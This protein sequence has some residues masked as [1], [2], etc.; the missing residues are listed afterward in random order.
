MAYVVLSVGHSGN[1]GSGRETAWVGV[2]EMEV[3]R[4]LYTIQGVS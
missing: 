3:Q 2:N 1:R 4:S